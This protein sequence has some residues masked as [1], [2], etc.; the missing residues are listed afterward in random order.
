MSFRRTNSDGRVPDCRLDLL[1]VGRFFFPGQTAWPAPEVEGYS[2]PQFIANGGLGSVWRAVRDSDG[3]FVALKA[4]N[5]GDAEPSER[6]IREA[7]ILRGLN[8]PGI[9][10]IMDLVPDRQGTPVLVMEY[11]EGSDL[12]KAVPAR[13]FGF[14][15]AAKIFLR[16][17]EAVDHAHSRGV[18]HRDIKPANILLDREGLP[19]LSD[20]GLAK[21]VNSESRSQALTQSGLIAGT[22]EYVA[23]ER[24]ESAVEE[25]AA[26]DGVA[27]DIYALGI[28][29]YEMLTGHLPRGAWVPL[30]RVKKLDIRLDQLM[31]DATHPDPDQRL[32][33]VAVFSRRLKDILESRPRFAGSTL[34]TLPVR[35]ADAAWT[36][37]GLYATGAGFYSLYRLEGA[38]IPWTFDL[39]GGHGALLG[40]YWSAWILCMILAMLWFWQACRLWMFRHVPI[41]EALPSPFG[42]TWGNGRGVCGIVAVGQFFCLFG[43]LYYLV[44]LFFRSN[45]WLSASTPFWERGLCVTERGSLSPVSPW[46]WMPGRFFRSQAYLLREVQPGLSPGALQSHGSQGFLIFIQPLLLLS[47]AGMI[48]LA[49]AVTMASLVREWRVRRPKTLALSALVMISFLIHVRAEAESHKRNRRGQE[50]DSRLGEIHAREKAQFGDGPQWHELVGAAF[51]GEGP[52]LR[53]PELVDR[54]FDAEITHDVKGLISRPE[55]LDW[56]LSEHGDSLRLRRRVERAT[57]GINRTG[58][59]FPVHYRFESYAEP[60][61]GLATGSHITLSW[62]GNVVADPPHF[63]FDQWDSESVTLYEVTPRDLDRKTL[64][65]WLER[66]LRELGKSGCPDLEPFALSTMLAKD[67]EDTARWSPAPRSLMVEAFRRDRERWSSLDF[68]L[69]RPPD[70]RLLSGGRWEITALINWLGI[71]ADGEN[72]Q[73]A[74][75]LTW[76]MEI[77]PVKNTWRI[78]RLEM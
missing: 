54:L 34:M 69:L 50:R 44:E 4:P 70:T 3:A 11:V 73:P 21:A 42:V 60:P 45:H 18:V 25:G 76:R 27:V 62:R 32:R 24:F 28:M 6:L 33:N 13:G 38:A 68:Y 46:T 26:V 9:V 29:F 19:K 36:L 35:L 61:G 41:R 22:M 47:G 58:D 1:E 23:P 14:E 59:P 12:T 56:L 55:L 53:L 49:M 37:V 5:E 20:F 51:G 31:T 16:I 67:H 10:R 75:P 77:V 71:R 39:T 65:A 64:N 48:G 8:H 72:E 2:S 57:C 63:V 30:S 40:G 43:G 78:L 66:F 17:L 7:D 15:E 52:A 74:G